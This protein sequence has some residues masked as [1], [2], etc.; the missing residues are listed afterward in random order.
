MREKFRRS[1]PPQTQNLKVVDVIRSRTLSA[2]SATTSFTPSQ[3]AQ[4]SPYLPR[5][6]PCRLPAWKGRFSLTRT[7]SLEN[8]YLFWTEPSTPI[9]LWDYL[10]PVLR[11]LTFPLMTSP[12]TFFLSPLSLCDYFTFRFLR[13]PLTVYWHDHR[14]NDVLSSSGMPPNSLGILSLSLGNK[15]MWAAVGRTIYDELFTSDSKNCAI[16][17]KAEK[18]LKPMLQ[19]MND[20][21]TVPKN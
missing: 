9:I 12:S 17:R 16:R 11:R 7:S 4:V 5:V 21:K 20:G 3:A 10:S 8:P 15:S 6:T 2:F 19:S 14:S 13:R 18:D 1:R